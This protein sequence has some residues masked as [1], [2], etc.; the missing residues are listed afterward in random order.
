M[1]IEVRMLQFASGLHTLR[2][3]PKASPTSPSSTLLLETIGRKA[4]PWVEQDGMQRIVVAR[5]AW[6]ELVLPPNVSVSHKKLVSSRTGVHGPR[7]YGNASGP[8]AQW[9]EDDQETK[10][11]S[12]LVC[13]VGGQADF[14]I[15]NY[16]LHCPEGTFLF[17]P[18]GVP[19]PGGGRSHLDAENRETGRCDLLWLSPQGSHLQCWMCSSHGEQHEV[20]KRYENVFPL[21]DQLI[22]FLN[23]MQEEALARHPDSEKL[24]EGSLRLFLLAVQREIKSGRFLHLD[25]DVPEEAAPSVSHDPIVRAQEYIMAHL[26]GTLTIDKVAQ[27]VHMSRAQF[28]RRFHQGTGQT[29]VEFVS[30]RRV[31]QAQVF[32]RETDWSVKQISDFVGF[33]SVPHFHTLFR[34][35]VGTTPR[36]FRR[37]CHNARHTDPA[38]GQ[39]EP[40][41]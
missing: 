14:Q 3:M 6:R 25:A 28:T 21:N 26:A 2:R 20:S 4:I 27:A 15:G 29:F 9:D 8:T 18:P 13:V 39:D 36:E 1:M 12:L 33:R 37:R 32:L 16:I 34:S 31:E 38:L 19:H 22:H 17:I 5:K 11:F 10:R 24:F 23:Y 35:L 30:A 40:I 7:L 41:P